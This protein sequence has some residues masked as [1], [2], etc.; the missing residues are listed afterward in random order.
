MK[1]ETVS[2]AYDLAEFLNK[3][4]RVE[5][6]GPVNIVFEDGTPTT[7]VVELKDGRFLRFASKETDG[8][9]CRKGLFVS[10]TEKENDDGG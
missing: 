4:D 3:E 8:D 6:A 9:G 5:Q 1:W 2:S 10:V 7:V